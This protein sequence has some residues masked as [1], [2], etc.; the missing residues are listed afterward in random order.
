MDEL[1][2]IPWG[3]VF[4]NFVWIIGASLILANFSY[5]EFL[6]YKEKAPLIK[7]LKRSS[8]KT[9]FHL[10]FILIAAG[11]CFSIKNP[12]LAGITG[13]AAFLLIFFSFKK[14]KRKT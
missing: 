4:A 7:V 2:R 9:F 1:I 14:L 8:F 3:K 5:H 10:G 11:A 13:G 6:A 12:W